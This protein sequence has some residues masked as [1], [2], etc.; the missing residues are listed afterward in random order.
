MYYV[1]AAAKFI[2]VL[3]SSAALESDRADLPLLHLQHAWDLA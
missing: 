1:G 3:G 2:A